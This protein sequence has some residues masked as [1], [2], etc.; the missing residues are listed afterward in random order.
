MIRK[1]YNTMILNRIE[2]S[3][4]RIMPIGS[5]IAWLSAI[6]VYFSN[7]PRMFIT[8]NIVIGGIF[9]VIALFRKQLKVEL[10][11]MITI[12]IPM[13]M[14]VISFMDGGFGSAG[15][16]LFMITN[17]V[18]VM[19][20]SKR[21]S[22]FI[23]ISSAIIFPML[24]A[25]AQAYPVRFLGQLDIAFWIIHYVV[26][27]L[28]LFILHTVVYSIKG[29]LLE[30]I[31]DLEGSVEKTYALAY[32]DSLTGLPN[33][34]KYMLDLEE[35]TKEEGH[36]YV[37][38]FNID[39]LNLINSIYSDE[40]GNQVL[41]KVAKI[42][43]EARKPN[44]L[45]ARI[46]GNEFSMWLDCKNIRE[47]NERMS[48]YTQFFY[49]HFNISNMTKRIEF[50]MSYM[51]CLPDDNIIDVFHKVKMALTYVK[52]QENLT[53]VPYDE[54]LEALLRDDE[55]LKER[56]EYALANDSFTMVYQTKYNSETN[57]LIGV[58]ALARLY[59]EKIG[60]VSPEVFVPKLEKMNYAN[61]FGEIIVKHVLQ[62]YHALRIKYGERC[63]IAINISPSHIV[64]KGFVDF[65]RHEII[66]YDILPQRI[67]IEITEEV[68]IE[69]FENVAEVIRH[70]KEIGFKVSLDDF[71]SGYSSLGYL[72]KLNIDEIKID[73]S[74]ISDVI[75]N[76]KM[77]YMVEMI[78]SLSK[79]YQ[80]NIVAEGVENEK[81]YKK[82]VALGCHDIQGYYLSKPEALS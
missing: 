40:I 59:D 11:I 44:E 12:S 74:F 24:Y 21:H 49:E 51:R 77:E 54:K 9:F 8:L 70:L 28:Y 34:N 39:N 31:E 60:Q 1:D 2:S 57:E 45:L 69:N 36:G 19:F 68:M 75:D 73:R 5:V 52:S 56:L 80:L 16:T 14:G 35:I 10:K 82:L 63:S 78:I 26:F 17:V 3:F 46:S 29:Y 30:N 38:I 76:K 33:Q 50:N 61:E 71:G 37:V 22:R 79:V 66:K 4:D 18:A 20:L 65:I 15:L 67:I 53:L 62:D 25:Y 13:F 42:I 48:G 32:Y 43:D 27:L 81:Q 41:V 55:V 23:A 47:F 58:E 64:S 6:V 7:I 72:T